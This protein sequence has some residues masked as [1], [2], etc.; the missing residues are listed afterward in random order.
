MYVEKPSFLKNKSKD[1]ISLI[2]IVNEISF[3]MFQ[4]LLKFLREVPQRWRPTTR[5][6]LMEKRP[7]KGF[8]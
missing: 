7:S 4:S 8:R 2:F 6:L 3:I 1:I 5:P